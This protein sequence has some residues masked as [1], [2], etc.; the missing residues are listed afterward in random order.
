MTGTGTGTGTG[1]G[2]SPETGPGPCP[3]T[4]SDHI[5]YQQQQNAKQTIFNE[6]YK[7]TMHGEGY[8]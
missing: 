1:L 4:F 5:S 3:E 6:K 2:T 8:L 7:I